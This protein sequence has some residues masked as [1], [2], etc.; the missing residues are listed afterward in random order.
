MSTDDQKMPPPVPES[1]IAGDMNTE[2]PLGWDQVPKEPVPDEQKRHSRIGGKGG[3]SQPLGK[4]DKRVE[5]A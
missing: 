1:K 2:E 3:I 5:G 4:D